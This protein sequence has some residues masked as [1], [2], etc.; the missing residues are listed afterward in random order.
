MV[1][2]SKSQVNELFKNIYFIYFIL[3]MYILYSRILL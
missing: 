3:K 2:K 1:K